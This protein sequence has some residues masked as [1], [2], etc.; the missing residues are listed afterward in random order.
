MA[1]TQESACAR[2]KST[3]MVMPITEWRHSVGICRLW[4][5]RLYPTTLEP[6]MAQ[7][8]WRPLPPRRNGSSTGENSWHA[9]NL[10]QSITTAR[11]RRR[12]QLTTHAYITGTSPAL[13]PR[14]SS[15]PS[16]S[17]PRF[18]PSESAPANEPYRSF[19]ESRIPRTRTLNPTAHHVGRSGAPQ[20]ARPR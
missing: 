4:S 15:S 3:V 11:S 7:G 5:V 10:L 9:Q 18:S 12:Q 1:I 20:E 16:T 6:P 17:R 14:A 13:R 2:P 19:N 8:W